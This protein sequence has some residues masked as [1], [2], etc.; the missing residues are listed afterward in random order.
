MPPEGASLACVSFSAEATSGPEEDHLS[1][2]LILISHSAA[3]AGRL[4]RRKMLCQSAPSLWLSKAPDPQ[5]H[6]KEVSKK[7]KY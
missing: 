3:F 2:H 4:G 5:Y 1:P 6:Q 7:R